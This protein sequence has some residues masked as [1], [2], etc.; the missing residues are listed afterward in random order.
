MCKLN[1]VF[2]AIPVELIFFRKTQIHEVIADILFSTS[3][4]LKI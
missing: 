2:L 3:R 1:A 4:K